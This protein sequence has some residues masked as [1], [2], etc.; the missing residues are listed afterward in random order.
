MST[1]PSSDSS[2]GAWVW[3][4]KCRRCSRVADFEAVSVPTRPLAEWAVC[5]G[6]IMELKSVERSAIDA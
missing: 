4:L 1:E 6:E 2:R 3:I 5:C